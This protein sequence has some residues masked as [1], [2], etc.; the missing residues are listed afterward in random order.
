MPLAF[1]VLGL[2]W[3]VASTVLLIA[4]PG[5]LAL[6]HANPLV[7]ALTHS[8]VLGFLATIAFGAAYQLAPVALGTTLNNPRGAWWHFG[9]HALGVPGMIYAFWHWDMA[10]LGHCAFVV[11]LGGG[12]F[13]DNIWRTVRRSKQRGIVAWSLA[14]AAGWLVL[15][16]LAGLTLAA[17]RYWNF[18][19][20]DPAALLR[21]HAHLGLIGL[22]VTL[23]QGV[24]FQL[25]PMFTLGEVSNWRP[26]NAGFWISQTGLVG[27]VPS[28]VFNE[29]VFAMAFA[30][31]LIT[32]FLFSGWSLIRVI[33]TRR[34][35][36][37][38]P[39]IRAFLR[40]LITMAA[41]AIIGLLLVWP[42]SPAESRLGGLNGM[43]YGILLLVGGLLP[44]IAG[45]MCKI[46]P[47]LIW[48]RAYGPKIGRAATPPA[49]S[50][51]NHWM[52]QWGLRLQ[53][54][55][56]IPLLLGA[57]LPSEPLLLT[58]SWLLAGGVAL[59]AGSMVQALRH[60]WWPVLLPGSSPNGN[61]R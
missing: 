51:A 57:S 9:L 38:E 45:M 37:L 4:H 17:N 42:E 29:A 47:F 28:L 53:G 54:V 52:E 23:L 22:F 35:R 21:A 24:T 27:L 49:S 36:L 19:G 15:T 10:L 25:V 48:M 8:C 26:I 50:L 30:L 46:V 12:L 61:V 56:V 3:L 40:G 16:L 18:I 34:K 2:A 13:A 59:F 43:V 7:V 31:I 1:M 58:G 55:A 32:G 20:L 60:L 6:P 41:A 33:G 5:I 44:C 39:G 11:A 14:L